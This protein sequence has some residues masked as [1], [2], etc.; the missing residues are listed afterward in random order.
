[1][2]TPIQQTGVT[3]PD[4]SLLPMT[5]RRKHVIARPVRILFGPVP[6]LSALGTAC[7][8]LAT[9]KGTVLVISEA[10]FVEHYEYIP[11]DV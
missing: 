9:R 8:V 11:G 7:Y 3:A 2:T 1:M 5:H 10:D 6:W 4:G